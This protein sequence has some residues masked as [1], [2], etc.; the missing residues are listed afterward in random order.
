LRIK[1][2][3]LSLLPVL[4]LACGAL[5]LPASSA[6]AATSPTNTA[7]A[8]KSFD[9]VVADTA[10]GYLFFSEGSTDY[11]STSGTGSILVTNLSGKTVTTFTGL[12]G[13]KG[14]VLSPDDP[15]L[16]AAVAGKNEI[17]AYSTKTLKVT[18]TYSTGS[19]MPVNLAFEDGVLWVSY[20]AGNTFSGGVGYINPASASPAFTAGALPGTW[21]W[22][23][24]ISGDP[25]KASAASTTGTLVAY[26]AGETPT[27][28]Y[29]FEIS[30]TAVTSSQSA[31]LSGVAGPLE[32]LPG[33]SQFLVGAVTYDTTDLSAGTVS[34]EI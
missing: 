27:P 8:L 24:F 11:S 23:P 25:S 12:T 21:W 20:W 16:Y 33:G 19:Y 22:P 32:V 6:S 7:L 30:G 29:S 34:G 4:A 1:A 15:T 5:M 31:S 17:V 14:L 3:S 13:V 2:L 10:Q 28:V 9:Q 18:G 26:S